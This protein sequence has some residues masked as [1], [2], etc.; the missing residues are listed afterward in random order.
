MFC[1][2][3]LLVV[4]H[5]DL[6]ESLLKSIAIISGEVKGS[7]SVGLYHGDSPVRLREEIQ[8]KVKKLDTGDGVL[9]LVDF[10]G[11]TPG[12]EVMKLLT[13]NEMKVLSG[14]NM[15]MLL[16]IVVNREFSTDVE[17]L[18]KTALQSGKESLQDL[19]EVYNNLIAKAG[20]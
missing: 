3:G 11:G 10:Y 13:T 6:G 15:A 5:G 12:N 7:A 17:A 2:I 9:V 8:D 20:E 19:N 14:V 18:A 1:L 16:E 4:T